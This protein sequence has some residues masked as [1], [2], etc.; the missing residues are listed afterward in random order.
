LAL[1]RISAALGLVLQM[2]QRGEIPAVALT[3]DVKLTQR[4]SFS[5]KN[6]VKSFIQQ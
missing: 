3:T 2:T 5:K 6:Q 1:P 4:P